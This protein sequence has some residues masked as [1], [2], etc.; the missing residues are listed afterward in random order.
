MKLSKTAIIGCSAITLSTFVSSVPVPALAQN[1][2]QNGGFVPTGIT[3]SA[4][5]QDLT[6]YN[7]TVPD[8]S[9]NNAYGF[10]VPDGTAVDNNINAAG[11]GTVSL[12]PGNGKQT[13]NDPT[14]ITN[15]WFIAADGGYNTAAIQQQLSG[16]TPGQQYTVDFYQA[17][18]QQYGYT[19]STTERF[20]VSLTDSSTVTS[21][22]AGSQ[23][24]ALNTFPTTATQVTPWLE[25]DLTFTAD[26]SSE[27]LSFLAVGT[28]TG[29]PP[30]S[31]LAD[32]SVNATSTVPEP[33]SGFGLGAIIVLGLGVGLKKSKL[34]N[35]K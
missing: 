17:A 7:A 4:D 1:L 15:G 16:L 20:Q 29:D 11:S 8:W 10:V 24:S 22:E 30:F 25:Q 18:G 12:Y 14:G 26:A 19:G 31:L 27:W 35:K 34:A 23:L 9:F 32:V 21:G 5:L 13:V 6:Q 3:E 28:P 2:V 33:L